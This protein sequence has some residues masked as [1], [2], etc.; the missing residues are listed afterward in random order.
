MVAHNQLQCVLARS[1]LQR[2]LGLASAEVTMMVI[3]WNWLPGWRQLL[4]VYQ[5]VMV[6]GCGTLDAGRGDTHA[7]QPELH[8]DR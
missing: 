8:G 5:Q 6:A 2:G 4:G 7:A 3:G 1:Q